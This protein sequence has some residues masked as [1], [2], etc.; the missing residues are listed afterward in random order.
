MTEFDSSRRRANC[1]LVLYGPGLSGKTTSLE[2]LNKKLGPKQC[3][4]IVVRQA[5]SKRS[6][7]FEFFPVSMPKYQDIDIRVQVYAVPGQSFYQRTR[8]AVLKGVDAVL[9]VA[10]SA[11][12]RLEANIDSCAELEENL[13]RYGES[14]AS[15]PHVIAYNKRDLEDAVAVETLRR[16]L[17]EHGAPDFEAVATKGTGVLEAFRALLPGLGKRV[18]KEI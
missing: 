6:L 2:F 13:T 3:G 15:I 17:N 10:D 14:L 11:S 9:F 8:K 16:E 4:R 7:V 5:E 12:S 1:K 18:K